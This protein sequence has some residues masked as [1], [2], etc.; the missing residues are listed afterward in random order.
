M[1]PHSRAYFLQVYLFIGV[2]IIVSIRY[3]SMPLNTPTHPVS[4]TSIT[5]CTIFTGLSSF[6]LVPMSTVPSVEGLHL[7]KRTIAGATHH[8]PVWCTS[9]IYIISCNM[10]LHIFDNHTLLVFK[11]QK[12]NI[13][14]V[15]YFWG[16]L[17][18][19]PSP[20]ISI[21]LMSGIFLLGLTS[22]PSI[23]FSA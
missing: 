7:Q 20:K 2:V 13:N 18:L 16:V 12:F 19:Y 21:K 17:S 11:F 9:H 10:F 1:C 15:L 5:P 14:I 3:A 4:V 8:H 23:Y 6:W 22:S